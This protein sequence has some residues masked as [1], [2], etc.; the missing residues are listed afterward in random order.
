MTCRRTS[1]RAAAVLMIL[2]MNVFRGHSLTCRRL[3]Y[4]MGTECCSMCLPGSRVKTHCTEFRPP[5]CQRCTEGTFMNHPTDL[6]QCF[7]CTNCDA[8][9]GLKLKTSCTA[10]SDAVC[11]PLE[12]F[13]CMDSAE[14]G[15]KAAEKHS[16]CQPGQ[17]ISQR[18]TA[19]RDT[20]CSDCSEGTYSDGTFPS[21]QPHTQCESVHLQLIKAGTVSTDAECGEQ[22]SD[23]RGL[24][25]GV[26]VLFYLGIAVVVVVV[27]QRE[28]N[29]S[30]HRKK[31][32]QEHREE[33]VYPAESGVMIRQ[34]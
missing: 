25:V 28:E 3:E 10:T 9:S 34:P 8:A 19:L 5:S 7:T 20:E 27:F 22:S 24:V 13:Y 21:C 33:P 32:K 4:Q 14:E 6:S 1:V 31:A 17:Y 23:S 11:E 2:V 15:C 18:G 12:G 16:S 30:K 26:S 29:K